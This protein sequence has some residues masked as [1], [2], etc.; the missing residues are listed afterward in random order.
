MLC[1][2][3]GKLTDSSD[4]CEHCGAALP[5]HR[6]EP[7]YNNGPAL[8]INRIL[9]YYDINLAT[10]E[11]THRKLEHLESV[12]KDS[13]ED[14]DPSKF[15]SDVQTEISEELRY[16]RL[17]LS[18]LMRAVKTA[19]DYVDTGSKELRESAVSLAESGT[20]MLNKAMKLNWESFE[21]V[22]ASAEEML[23]LAQRSV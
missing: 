12:Y 9:Y 1:L 7:P 19:G 14:T 4:K 22:R 16:G 6:S 21:G 11:E 8:E 10:A 5:E 2:N 23:A 3:C 15:A 13:Y 17:G 18:S 20:E